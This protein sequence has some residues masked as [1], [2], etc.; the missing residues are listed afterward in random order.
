MKTKTIENIAKAIIKIA[1]NI[2]IITSALTILAGLASH[3]YGYDTISLSQ[4]SFIEWSIDKTT[5]TWLVTLLTT[6]INVAIIFGLVKLKEFVSEFTL[7]MVLSNQTYNFLKKATVYTFVVALFQNL[8]TN[9][10]NPSNM[11]FDFSICG[12]LAIAVVISKWLRE[13]HLA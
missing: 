11:T 13:R 12:F 1:C 3:F 2:T 7:D 10:N 9:L 8:L 4:N 5:N 6:A